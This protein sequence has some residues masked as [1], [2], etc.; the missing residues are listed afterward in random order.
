MVRVKNS[1]YERS[2]QGCIW[3]KSGKFEK[4]TILSYFIEYTLTEVYRYF[5]D[6]LR[7]KMEINTF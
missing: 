1:S 4:Y 6:I 2:L 3:N 7:L 5:T